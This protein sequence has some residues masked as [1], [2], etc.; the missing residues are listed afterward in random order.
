MQRFS[1]GEKI[2]NILS[3]LCQIAID[4]RNRESNSYNGGTFS[5]IGIDSEQLRK[6]LAEEKYRELKEVL[7]QC[8]S[9]WYFEKRV[10]SQSGREW[11]VLYYNRWIC[12]KFDLPLAYG[13][14]KPMKA[15]KLNSCL[16]DK[17]ISLENEYEYVKMPWSGD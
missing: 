17:K 1:Y 14:W 10:I 2:Q 7:R 15:E 12:L 6:I 4:E 9:A 16:Y 11:V 3:N 5:G 8:I 13:G